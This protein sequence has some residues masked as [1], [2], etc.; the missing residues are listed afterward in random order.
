MPEAVRT[1]P[2]IVAGVLFLAA[3]TAPSAQ[4]GYSLDDYNVDTAQDLL[5]VCT[6]QQGDQSYWEAEAFCYGYFQGGADFH[7]ALTSGPGGK[8]LVCPPPDVKIRDAVAVFVTYAR[9]HPESLD[10]APMDVAFRAVSEKW[11]CR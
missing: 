3:S 5:D 8:P 1:L 6:V 4:E 7:Q 10:R 9:A 11:P 2:S